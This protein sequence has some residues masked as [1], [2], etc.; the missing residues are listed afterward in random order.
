MTYTNWQLDTRVPSK[1]LH[2]F[3]MQTGL[4]LLAPF[5]PLYAL[6]CMVVTVRQYAPVHVFR[7]M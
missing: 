2:C 1:R 3:L 4:I 6:A 7:T 5:V